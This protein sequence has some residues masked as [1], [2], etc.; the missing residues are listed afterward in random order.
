LRSLVWRIGSSPPELPV[1]LGSMTA[2]WGEAD[3]GRTRSRSRLESSPDR[4]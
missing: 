3:A 1:C 2:S 4:P